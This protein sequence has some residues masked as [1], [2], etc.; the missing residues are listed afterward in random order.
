MASGDPNPMIDLEPFD[1]ESEK[2]NVIIDTPKGSRNKFKYDERS[3]IFKL[4]VALPLAA[5]FPF[6]FGSFLFASA[7]SLQPE[8]KT[9][10]PWMFC[11]LW[12]ILPFPAVWSKPNS[13][14]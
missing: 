3:Q 9:A 7:S 1:E 11:F 2:L 8:L 14:E 6:A 4:G 5:F 13:L 10:I 12:T